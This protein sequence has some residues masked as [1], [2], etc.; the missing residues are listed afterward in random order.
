MFFKAPTITVE[1][2]YVLVLIGYFIKNLREYLYKLYGL[3]WITAGFTLGLAIL[4]PQKKKVV[5]KLVDFSSA[6]SQFR[7]VS[8]RR[9][10]F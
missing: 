10:V 6:N 2:V 3:I 4:C 8:S 9:I 7:C 5:P 1:L